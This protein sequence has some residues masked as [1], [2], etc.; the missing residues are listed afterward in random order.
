[1]REFLGELYGDV[2][3]FD[4]RPTDSQ[5]QRAGVLQRELEDVI[6]EFNTLTGRD[7]TAINRGLQSKQM[8]A[9]Q[10][11]SETDWRKSDGNGMT[12]GAMQFRFQPLL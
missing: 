6:A 12:G 2:N 4:G 1:M 7:L 3:G 10:V 9:I 11:I 8:G 5:V